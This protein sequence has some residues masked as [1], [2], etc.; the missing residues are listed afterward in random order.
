MIVPHGRITQIEVLVQFLKDKHL[1]VATAES[2]TGGLLGKS[3]T[4]ISGSSAVYPGGVISYCNRIKH[5]ILGV[6]QTLLDS[7]GP[8][9]EPV[10]RQMAEGVRRV[11]GADL[12]IGI[13]GIAGPNSDD[14]GRPVGLVYVS[15]SNGEITMARE[16]KFD[17]DRNAIRCMAAEAAA[18]LAVELI[19]K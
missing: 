12:G 5:D 18:D 6:D 17:G 4:D 13:T 16:C 2:C 11:I 7:L 14:T 8:V 15:A 10:A 1:T 19:E 3:I 9:S